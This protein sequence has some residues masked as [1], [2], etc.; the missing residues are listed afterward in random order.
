MSFPHV[1][2]PTVEYCLL[3]SQ[4]HFQGVCERSETSRTWKYWLVQERKWNH[5]LVSNVNNDVSDCFYI[6][7][8]HS[9]KAGLR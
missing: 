6:N 8:Y 9:G 5:S 7:V 3:I 4:A 2:E 1:W